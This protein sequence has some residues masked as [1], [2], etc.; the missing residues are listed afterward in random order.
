[1]SSSDVN[2]YLD[3]NDVLKIPIAT[4]SKQRSVLCTGLRFPKRLA[5][6]FHLF[7]RRLPTYIPLSRFTKSE[8]YGLTVCYNTSYEG[9]VCL[10]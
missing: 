6:I 4:L 2:L 8:I 7:Y 9:V 5:Q 1:M 10:D 3:T